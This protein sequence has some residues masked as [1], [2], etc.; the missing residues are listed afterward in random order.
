MFHDTDVVFE[1]IDTV[2]NLWRGQFCD[3]CSVFFCLFVHWYGIIN[4][5]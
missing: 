2:L 1:Y 3:F 4:Y 5:L